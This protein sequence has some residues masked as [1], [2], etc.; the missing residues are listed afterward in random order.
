MRKIVNKK[1]LYCENIRFKWLSDIKQNTLKV[2]EFNYSFSNVT[3][4][5]I[6]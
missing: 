5:Q 3:N 6:E 4:L 1:L 2:K